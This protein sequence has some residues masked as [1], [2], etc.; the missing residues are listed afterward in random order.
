VHNDWDAHQPGKPG[1][2][3]EF[4]SDQEKARGMYS[5]LFFVTMCNVTDSVLTGLIEVTR[6]NGSF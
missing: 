6:R 5:C 3:R 1:K 4:E 2:V